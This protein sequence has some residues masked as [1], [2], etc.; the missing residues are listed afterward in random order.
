MHGPSKALKFGH[1]KYVPLNPE[2]AV[3]A[4]TQLVPFVTQRGEAFA[5][6]AMKSLHSFSVVP[7]N[8]VQTLSTQV[9]A[10]VV[11]VFQQYP[12]APL[13]PLHTSWVPLYAEHAE[14]GGRQPA[15]LVTHPLKN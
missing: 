9:D 1:V 4:G 14:F 10:V 6:T 12:L 8:K 5:A 15:P 2:H 7:A 11:L 13:N 3:A